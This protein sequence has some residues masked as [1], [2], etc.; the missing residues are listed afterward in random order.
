MNFILTSSSIWKIL[1]QNQ[2][3]FYKNFS[4]SQTFLLFSICSHFTSPSQRV[5]VLNFQPPRVSPRFPKS[6][7]ASGSTWKVMSWVWMWPTSREASQRSHTFAF[8]P[9]PLLLLI[10]LL[11]TP[12]SPDA[13]AD[14]APVALPEAMPSLG[15]GANPNLL[16]SLVK[17]VSGVIRNDK[18]I[19]IYFSF[20]RTAENAKSLSLISPPCPLS[21]EKSINTCWT[22]RP[23]TRLRALPKIER[24]FRRNWTKLYIAWLRML[25]VSWLIRQLI[26]NISCSLRSLGCSGGCYRRDQ[27]GQNA[28]P[29]LWTEICF[30]Q[31]LWQWFA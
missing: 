18:L 26:T 6:P 31:H 8:S 3:I 20:Q 10:C 4:S 1:F 28:D 22:S 11:I 5:H 21:W 30:W 14:P 25:M 9:G 29:G 19:T 13:Y 24:T 27:Q 2:K 23:P 15:A 12:V 7:S 17:R 16:E